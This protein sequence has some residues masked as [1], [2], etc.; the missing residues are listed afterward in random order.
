MIERKVQLVKE[1]FV[2]LVEKI[3]MLL[4][5]PFGNVG[6]KRDGN[7][8]FVGAANIEGVFPLQSFKAGITVR[9]KISAGNMPKMELSI[10][11]GQSRRDENL[12]DFLQA[13]LPRLFPML[14]IA[15]EC[16]ESDSFESL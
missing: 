10:G 3:D 9:G 7:A 1:V 11:I 15:L 12:I 16:K 14:L 13:E 8:I 4:R 6:A 2:D 5:R